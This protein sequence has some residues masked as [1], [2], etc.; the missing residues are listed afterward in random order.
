LL[1]LNHDDVTWDCP[2]RGDLRRRRRR[3]LEHTVLG[4]M[5]RVVKTCSRRQ[6]ILF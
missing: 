6:E 5:T 2:N 1:V 4:R 3:T